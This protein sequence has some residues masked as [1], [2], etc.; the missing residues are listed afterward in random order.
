MVERVANQAVPWCE[1]AVLLTPR[2][3]ENGGGTSAAAIRRSG[4]GHRG[5]GTFAPDPRAWVTAAVS[6]VRQE[7]ERGDG[8][9]RE[10]GGISKR[11]ARKVERAAVEAASTGKTVCVTIDSAAEGGAGDAGDGGSAPSWSRVVCFSPVAVS[12]WPLASERGTVSKGKSGKAGHSG[13]MRTAEL[14]GGADNGDGEI[15]GTVG[16]PCLIAWMLCLGNGACDGSDAKSS[17]GSPAVSFLTDDVASSLYSGAGA[18]RSPTSPVLPLPHQVSTAMEAVVHAVHL[19]LSSAATPPVI[20]GPLERSRHASRPPSSRQAQGL[21]TD[22][23]L[24]PSSKENRRERK[25]R[26]EELGRLREGTAALAER[27]QSLETRA[28]TL[29][30][31]E[32][33]SAAALAR[34]RADIAAVTGQLQL[35][36]LERD[37]LSR[38]L[39]ETGEMGASATVATAVRRETSQRGGDKQRRKPLGASSAGNVDV[40][41]AFQAFSRSGGVLPGVFKP[42]GGMSSTAGVGG[43][44]VAA[45]S[46]R[47]SKGITMREGVEGCSVMGVPASPVTQNLA[48]RDGV[49]DVKKFVMGGD[50]VGVVEDKQSHTQSASLG[51]LSV[52]TSTINDASSAALQHMASLHARLSVSLKRGSGTLVTPM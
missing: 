38:R 40:D 39:E 32:A 16:I 42:V 9:E 34:A 28:A 26:D 17:P 6:R 50:G 25:A 49:V 5:G 31:S 47:H 41:T 33:R 30:A 11:A 23:F 12:A 15:G 35:T 14:E 44:F 29:R 46:R 22:T 37:R 52:Q 20:H 24:S 43:G 4:A 2:R 19:A 21:Q 36:A 7:E 8:S 10:W 3:G 18:E 27:V 1:G 13:R 48:Q 45:D 51:A